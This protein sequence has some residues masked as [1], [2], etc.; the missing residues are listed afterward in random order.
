LESG[1]LVRI[2]SGG[3]TMTAAGVD[4]DVPRPYA[5]CA[6]VDA[7]GTVRFVSI[8][9]AALLLVDPDGQQSGS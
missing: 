4:Y 6:W 7:R 8:D 2:K 3:P 1:D 9:T 5:R